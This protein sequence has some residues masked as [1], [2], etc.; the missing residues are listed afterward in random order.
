MMHIMPKSEFFA[1][2]EQLTIA[3]C[4]VHGLPHDQ[5]ADPGAVQ[6]ILDAEKLLAE[7]PPTPAESCTDLGT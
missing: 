3:Y 5:P 1:L 7:T 2:V 6:A 4:Q